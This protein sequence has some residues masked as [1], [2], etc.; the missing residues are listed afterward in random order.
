MKRE[1]VNIIEI[2]SVHLANRNDIGN[3][4]LNLPTMYTHIH[5]STTELLVLIKKL[6]HGRH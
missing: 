3:N 5:Q 2:I 1:C 4:F 6:S